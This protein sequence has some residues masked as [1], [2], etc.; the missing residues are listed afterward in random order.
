MFVDEARIYVRAGDGG[1]GA[2]SFRREKFVPRGG[3]DGGDG[4]RGGSVYVVADAMV[5][6]L[7][8]FRRRRHF[9]AR[10]GGNGRGQNRHGAKGE[11]L[12][13]K[14]PPGTVVRSDGQVLADLT[15]AGQE[16]MVARGGRGG[17]GNTHFATPTRQAPRIAQK[18]EPGEE[19][20]LELEL[21][22]IADVGIIGY[23]NVG[24]STFLAAVTRATPKIGDYA[25]TTLTPN[26]GVAEVHHVDFVLA[27]IPGLIEG[28]HRGVGLGHQFLRHVERTRVLI[29]IVDGTVEEPVEDFVRVNEELRLFNPE[30]AGKPQVV[31]FN[32]VDVPSARD[33]W[34]SVKDEFARRGVEAYPVSAAS[35]EGLTEVLVRAAELLKQAGREREATELGQ[36]ARLFTPQPL[37]G[38]FI[39]EREVGGY[40]VRGR[41]VERAVAMTDMGNDE[42]T[43]RAY[44]KKGLL[45][46]RQ[47]LELF[48]QFLPDPDHP[49]RYERVAQWL[50][51]YK[52]DFAVF[53]RIRLGAASTLESM[54]LDVF[55]YM[56][57]DDPDLIHEVHSRFSA[58]SA[59]VVKHLNELDFDFLWANDDVAGNNGPFMSPRVLREFLLPHMKTVAQE[60]KK[61]WIFH[62]DGN[63][64]PLLPDLLTL[65]MNAIHPIQPVAMDIGRMKREY[66]D[67]VAIAGNIDLDYTLTLGTPEEVDAEVRQRIATAGPGGGYMVTSANSLTNYCKT[68]NVLA[69]ARAI[70]K[71]GKYPLRLG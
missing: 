45:D 19:C 23:P 65:G 60:I 15:E 17:L 6:S 59:R 47:A 53:A 35:G 21:K 1:N 13:I 70:E 51:Q 38:D 61:P 50:K 52:Q 29:H 46:S 16:V 56:L 57:Y 58:W 69:M 49:A 25:F 34:W 11:D 22:L 55:G 31:A 64:F 66:G 71:Y 9:R 67:R 41:L 36:E 24:K 10:P 26:L 54:G 20:W 68:E 39:V 42:A 8:E 28:A 2:V 48:D 4:G 7:S 32:K 3:P 5:S 14:V 43:G 12:I 37:A 63:L 33:R 44:I 27:D 40:R 18:G 30:L 62:S